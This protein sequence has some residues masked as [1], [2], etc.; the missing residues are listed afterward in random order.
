MI[1]G[2]FTWTLSWPQPQVV[3][4]RWQANQAALLVLGQ[5]RGTGTGGLLNVPPVPWQCSA[6]T[7]LPSCAWHPCRLLQN[8]SCDCWCLLAKSQCKMERPGDHSCLLPQPGSPATSRSQASQTLSQ[9][10]LGVPSPAALRPPEIP[11][12]PS[13]GL[14]PAGPGKESKG[15]TSQA[16]AVWRA[17]SFGKSTLCCR[18][19]VICQSRWTSGYTAGAEGP[20]H[21]GGEAGC[22]WPPACGPTAALLFL[23][24]QRDTEKLGPARVKGHLAKGLEAVRNGWDEAVKP[25]KGKTWGPQRCFQYQCLSC[26]VCEVGTENNIYLQEPL[27]R[28]EWVSI[29]K[30]IGMVCYL[31]NS[32]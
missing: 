9:A 3:S 21:T 8:G 32:Q 22:D 29:H 1:L 17:A 27:W 14:C 6:R 28:L 7:T 31:L 5:T 10:V 20:A 2:D 11:K 19:V 15:L 18:S 12:Q 4:A 23:A 24:I 16:S 26:L 25:G 30:M 13:C